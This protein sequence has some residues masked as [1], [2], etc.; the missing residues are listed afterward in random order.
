MAADSAV[1]VSYA[2]CDYSHL[3]FEVED[4]VDNVCSHKLAWLAPVVVKRNSVLPLVAERSH[5]NA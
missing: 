5:R 4:S 1:S 2:G 3:H